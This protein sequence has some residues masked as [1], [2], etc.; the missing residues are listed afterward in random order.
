MH[1]L[2]PETDNCP[3]WISGRERMTVE[4]ILW[5]LSTKDCCRPRRGLNPRPPGLQSDGA[6]NWATEAGPAEGHNDA[7][8]CKWF[9]VPSRL[10]W[11]HRG[12]FQVPLQLEGNYPGFPSSNW[13][14]EAGPAG[15]I[16]MQLCVNG[17]KFPLGCGGF[18]ASIS[19]PLY[20][21]KETTKG[22]LHRFNVL[23]GNSQMWLFQNI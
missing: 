1:I 17:W 4:N 5:S 18:T 23:W 22:F 8:R 21:W 7:V 11:F 10:R 15:D 13:A 9:E 16:M 3:S 6:S 19:K 12:Y 20:N 2:S 14:T